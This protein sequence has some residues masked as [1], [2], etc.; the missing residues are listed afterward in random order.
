MRFVERLSAGLGYDRGWPA[1]TPADPSAGVQAHPWGHPYSKIPY[2]THSIP[3]SNH[4]IPYSSHSISYASYSRNSSSGEQAWGTIADGQ[5][6]PWFEPRVF[7]LIR[8][9]TP[10]QEFPVQLI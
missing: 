1:G 5:L 10:I 8:G 2:S 4:S 6:A 7:R 3:Y 9:D